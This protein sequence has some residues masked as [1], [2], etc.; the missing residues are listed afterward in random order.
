MLN[1]RKG[2]YSIITR[3]QR[4]NIEKDSQEYLCERG[5]GRLEE[6]EIED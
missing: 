2:N 4:E 5:E 3:I 1:K 6:A